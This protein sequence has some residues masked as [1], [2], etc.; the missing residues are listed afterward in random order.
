M[1]RITQVIAKREHAMAMVTGDSLG[2]VASQ[3]LRNLVAVDAAATMPVF[4]PL[5]GT[6]KLDILATARKIGTYDISSEPFHDCCPVFLP[7]R[8]A[9]F[10]KTADLEAAESSLDIPELIT[11]GVRGT[12]IERLKFSGGQVSVTPVVSGRKL[13]A[14]E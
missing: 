5:I 1:L 3:T 11:R 13:A 4:R 8:P 12:S 10:A 6:D 2:Q 9:L 14:A 7:R